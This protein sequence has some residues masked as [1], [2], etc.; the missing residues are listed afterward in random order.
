M[1]SQLKR[2]IPKPVYFRLR[3]S[4]FGNAWRSLSGKGQVIEAKAALL[5]RFQKE[6][7]LRTL[8]ETGTY[9]GDTLFRVKNDFQN[10]Y[11]IELD[12]NLH[13]Y[14]SKRFARYPHIHLVRGDSAKMLPQVL[15]SVQEPC[16]LWLDAHWSGGV[17]GKGALDSAVSAELEA[18]RSHPIKEHV[19]LIDDISSG[20][21]QRETGYLSVQALESFFRGVNPRYRFELQG[22]VGMAYPVK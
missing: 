8:I 9:F 18:I 20:A 1:L 2:A 5:K 22:D 6:R 12:E 16:L 13:R 10:I 14:A 21:E 19:V 4:V 3:N 17:T 7:G 15:S 11:S